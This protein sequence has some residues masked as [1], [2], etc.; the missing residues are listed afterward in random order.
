MNSALH[1][2]TP[3]PPH[4]NRGTGDPLQHPCHPLKENAPVFWLCKR[5]LTLDW[6]HV[7][8]IHSFI[9]FN[10]FH[11]F[12]FHF[13]SFIHSLI[14]SFIDSF[15]HS[16]IHFNSF[17]FFSFHFFSFIHS[18]IHSFIHYFCFWSFWCST[19]SWNKMFFCFSQVKKSTFGSQVACIHAPP[20]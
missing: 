2:P 9:H 3:Q 15:I 18:L 7:K 11:F 4:T 17:H 19:N 13:F 16:F 8:M 12:S 10:S 6:C 20:S 5:N 14:H 1:R